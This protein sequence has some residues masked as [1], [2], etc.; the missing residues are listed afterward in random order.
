[1]SQTGIQNVLGF[2]IPYIDLWETMFEGECGAVPGASQASNRSPQQQG[3]YLWA[4]LNCCV[5]RVCLQSFFPT[6]CWGTQT[7]S[8]LRPRCYFQPQPAG[9]ADLTPVPFI[10]GPDPGFKMNGLK[11]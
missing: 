8:S 5:G 2:Y 4:Q 3:E 7:V 6:S 1:M 9:G 11:M 10:Q